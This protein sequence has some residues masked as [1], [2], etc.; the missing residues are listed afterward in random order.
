MTCLG[1]G[2]GLISIYG[3]FVDDL[4]TEFDAGLAAINAGPVALLLVPG[5]VGP[6][7]GRLVDSVPVRRLMLTGSTIGMLSLAL[8]SQA[9]TLLLAG[10][11]FLGFALGV[12]LY[13]PVVVNAMLVRRFPHREARALAI[14]AIGISIASMILPPLVGFLL[15]VVDWRSTLLGLS[16]ALLIVLWLVIA[17][18]IDATDGAV[19]GTEA[20]A[21]DKSFYR[22]APFWLIGLCLALAFNVTIILSVAYAPYFLDEGFTVAQAGWFLSLAGMG[23]F[24][25]KLL[26]AW[27]ADSLRA[28]A[29]WIAVVLLLVQAAGLLLLLSVDHSVGVLA[30]LFL[31]GFGGGGMIPIHPYLNSR[32]FEASVIGQVNG[33]QMPLFLPFGLI[34][35]PLAGYTYDQ[36]GSYEP[37][38]EALIGV[39]F[40]AAVLV[41]ILPRVS[42]GPETDG[43]SVGL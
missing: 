27:L 12:S 4:A 32:Y 13:G 9:P 28:F 37:V 23:G 38:M 11:A 2:A 22:R 26:I 20:T 39:L 33:A 8:A 30:S 21:S 25:G 6:L 31:L 34:G 40:L 16:L 5:L 43:Q 19:T 18:S 36:L 42:T 1:L 3:F 15:S 41:V 14:A 7:V 24:T 17:S 10:L 29:K 35:A